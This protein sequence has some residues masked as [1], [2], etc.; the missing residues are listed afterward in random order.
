VDSLN[1]RWGNFFQSYI[2][3]QYKDMVS[4]IHF[5]LGVAKSD[6]FNRIY[7]DMVDLL[8]KFGKNDNSRN[9]DACEV[10]NFKTEVSNP[11]E[12]CVAGR[13]RDINIFFLLAEALWIFAGRKD[14]AFLQIFNSQMK[15]YS[16]DGVNFHAPYGYRIRN[17]GIS[18]FVQNEAK[19]GFDQMQRALQM[20]E[21]NPNDRRIVL[22]IWNYELDLGTTSKDIPCNDLWMWKVRDGKLHT[23]IA[24]RSNDINWGLPTN[25][26]QFSFM[27][28]LCA[29]ILGLQ[30]G[31]QVHN[32]QSLHMYTEGKMGELTNKILTTEDKHKTIE[33][34]TNM[35]SREFD[36]N[37]SSTDAT[38][39]LKQIDLV[40]NA[41]INGL[42]ALFTDSE[43]YESERDEILTMIWSSSEYL[44]DVY[45]ILEVY[46]RYKLN[47]NKR[48][49]L[50]EIQEIQ[51]E[52]FFE[53]AHE[54]EHEE[55]PADYVVW[56]YLMLAE[57][58]FGKRTGATNTYQYV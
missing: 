21:N 34:G 4:E 52:S 13:S 29:N 41:M 6:N 43:K 39:R 26:F 10:L 36:F 14:V 18:S 30:L 42:T 2:K 55:N 17:A 53:H 3:K 38:E 23:T 37:Y 7:F 9:G 11:Y 32:S 54:H 44:S 25:I 51:A 15:E 49:A 46:V 47:K 48:K 33:Y 22:Q 28:E 35:Q 56:D 31:S 58:F 24:N 27:G 20:A 8:Y 57:A 45:R 5:D 19:M 1:I 50:D 16:D 40:I 12:R